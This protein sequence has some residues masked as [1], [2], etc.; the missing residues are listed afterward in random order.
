[1]STSKKTYKDL[2]IPFFKEVFDDIDEIM[3]HHKVPYYLIGASAVA[4]QIMHKDRHPPRGTKDIDFAIMISS[5]DEFKEITKSFEKKGY[6]KVKA[7]WTFYS[8]AYKIAID[9]LPFGE[10]EQNDTINFS[11]RSIDLHVLGFKEVLN[12]PKE[13]LIE[14]KIANVPALS[15]MII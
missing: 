11:E 5:L 1:M 3:V 10:I 7:P 2:S 12:N 13:V 15:G 14:D 4:L 9:I 8:E 6:N